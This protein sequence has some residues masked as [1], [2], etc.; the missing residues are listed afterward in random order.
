MTI[1]SKLIYISFT[2]LALLWKLTLSCYSRIYT[3]LFKESLGV[4]LS[5]LGYWLTFLYRLWM[6]YFMII[7]LWRHSCLTCDIYI[8]LGFLWRFF[9]IVFNRFLPCHIFS[10][11]FY[12]FYGVLPISN[13]LETKLLIQTMRLIVVFCWRNWISTHFLNAYM[14]II[15]QIHDL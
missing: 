3:T 6:L 15:E 10:I 13:L 4:F 8:T 1:S 12:L 5:V 14:L 2:I 11:I 9:W 7:R